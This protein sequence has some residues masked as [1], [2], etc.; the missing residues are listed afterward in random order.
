LEV[1]GKT[2]GKG[3]FLDKEG[4][5]TRITSLQQTVLFFSLE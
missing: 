1:A 2:K 5:A 3:F 4:V